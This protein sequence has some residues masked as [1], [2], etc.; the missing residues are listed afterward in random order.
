[1]PLRLD[2]SV[3]VAGP[4]NLQVFLPNGVSYQLSSVKRASIR[5]RLARM[6]LSSPAS[7]S[8]GEGIGEEPKAGE[9]AAFNGYVLIRTQ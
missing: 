7:G 3:G 1:M 2:V 8:C 5:T 4:C 9:V 6:W